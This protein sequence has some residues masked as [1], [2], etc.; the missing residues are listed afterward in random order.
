MCCINGPALSRIRTCHHRTRRTFDDFI[1]SGHLA[2][3]P[4]VTLL[5]N[6]QGRR[7]GSGLSVVIG[8]TSMCTSHCRLILTTTPGVSP[9]FC[10]AILNS[11]EIGVLCKR[12]CQVLSRTITTLI[13][14]K[15]T[16]LRATLFHI[17]RI[18]YCCATYNG[19]MSFLHQRVLGM[20]C[21][22]LIG[23]ITNHRIIH[24]LMTSNVARGQI[25]RRLTLVLPS[26]NKQRGV[27]SNCRSVTRLLKRPKTPSGT[28]TVVAS[29]LR[30]QGTNG[31]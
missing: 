30:T 2:N 6:D 24:R 16:A 27:L 14:S 23:L 10:T 3:G 31:L 22:S 11:I 20:G 18:I 7:V 5:T 8:T 9:S 19:L 4:V 29:L 21:V 15:A 28:T 25:H 12:A 1:N 13:A 17:P 26:K